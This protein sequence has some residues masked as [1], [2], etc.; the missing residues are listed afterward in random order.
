MWDG[1]IAL[2]R[3]LQATSFTGD[4][5]EPLASTG[6]PTAAA[7]ATHLVHH[8][9]ARQTTTTGSLYG[10]GPVASV[11][12]GR[13]TTAQILWLLPHNCHVLGP[14]ALGPSNSPRASAGEPIDGVADAPFSTEFGAVI[15]PGETH[16]DPS[17]EHHFDQ[18]L[19]YE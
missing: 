18:A 19:Q 12:F 3:S 10:S 2:R 14:A 15:P 9:I 5:L 7:S 16:G 6:A 4:D 1:S 11:A 17:F 13:G 8:N